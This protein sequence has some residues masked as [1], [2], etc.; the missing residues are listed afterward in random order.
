MLVTFYGIRAFHEVVVRFQHINAIVHE[1][2]AIHKVMSSILDRDK[3]LV[4]K[5]E[6]RKQND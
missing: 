3:N 5:Q 6:C 2:E 4:Q 1:V